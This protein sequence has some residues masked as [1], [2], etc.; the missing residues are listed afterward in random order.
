[1]KLTL[2]LKTDILDLLDEAKKTMQK[3]GQVWSD[4][5]ISK[6]CFGYGDFIRSL[7]EWEGGA[8]PSPTMGNVAKLEQFLRDQI[9]EKDYERFIKKRGYK[10]AADLAFES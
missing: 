1:M 9:G 7:R 2:K 10:S 5:G 3:N 6:A 8:K 4:S